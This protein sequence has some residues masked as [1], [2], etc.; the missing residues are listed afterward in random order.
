MFG[1]SE[2]RGRRRQGDGREGDILE[3]I[4]MTA[5]TTQMGWP[6]GGSSHTPR[7]NTLTW[8]E[9][10]ATP[11]HTHAHLWRRRGCLSMVCVCAW[12]IQ[13]K[14][15]R[16]WKFANCVPPWV[17]NVCVR[18]QCLCASD[19]PG[20]LRHLNTMVYPSAATG[21]RGGGPH[22]SVTW[23]SISTAHHRDWHAL[24]HRA[25]VGWV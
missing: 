3:T 6:G 22:P 20:E 25:R 16:Q 9:M 11:K 7:L 19:S 5:T 18:M 14:R 21:N 8:L 13:A 10:M 24:T 17:S 2:W 1:I 4:T 23:V 15:L 12:N